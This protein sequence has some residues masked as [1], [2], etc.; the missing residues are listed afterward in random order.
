MSEYRLDD[1]IREGTE[2]SDKIVG[3]L[4]RRSDQKVKSCAYG[5]AQLGLEK[6]GGLSTTESAVV[7][8]HCIHDSLWEMST[9]WINVGDIP[10]EV[11]NHFSYVGDEGWDL[12]QVIYTMND[13]LNKSRKAIAE[14][15]E[16]LIDEKGYDLTIDLSPD[17]DDEE[18]EERELQ[19]A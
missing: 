15:V 10:D 13:D 7:S 4:I 14:Y 11:T 5:A 17:E 2:I 3:D 19:P 1:L 18:E 12:Y 9:T 8:I 6:K 16:W